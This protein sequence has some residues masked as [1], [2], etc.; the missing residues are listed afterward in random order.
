MKQGHQR[1]ALQ[2][3]PQR[4][5][6]KA[7][8]IRASEL[9]QMGVCEQRIVFEHRHGPKRTD[10]ERGAM[11]QGQRMH[12]LYHREALRILR[13]PPSFSFIRRMVRALVNWIVSMCRSRVG[14]GADPEKGEQGKDGC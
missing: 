6:G 7:K 14:R 13:K 1:S 2:R 4:P 9:A 10:Q 3:G 12:D 8:V 11:L 5:I